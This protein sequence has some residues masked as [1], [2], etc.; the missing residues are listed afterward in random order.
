[1][2]NLLDDGLPNQPL[3]G[4]SGVLGSPLMPSTARTV[5]SDGFAAAPEQDHVGVPWPGMYAPECR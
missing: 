5:S 3:A 4:S 1:M 2:V